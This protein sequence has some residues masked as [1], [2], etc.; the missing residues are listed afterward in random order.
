MAYIVPGMFSAIGV[1]LLILSGWRWIRDPPRR[2]CPGPRLSWRA[3]LTPLWFIYRPRCGYDLRGHRPGAHGLIV[4]PECARRI[5]RPGQMVRTSRAWRPGAA[6]CL[7]IVAA[8]VNYRSPPLAATTVVQYMPTE[9]LLRGESTLGG[10]T[11]L[12]MREEIRRRAEAFELDDDQI[13]RFVRLLVHDLRDDH[14]RGNAGDALGR[15]R[16]FGLICPEPLIEALDSH[17]VQQ[18]S[19]AASVLRAMPFDAALS[20]VLVRASVQDLRSD[21]R[22][23]NELESYGWLAN[24]VEEA[25][26]L[27]I[28][29]MASDDAQQRRDAMELLRRTTTDGA[30]FDSL[31]RMSVQDLRSDDREY[32]AYGGFIFLL[33]HA[34]AAEP[35]LR[36]A[37]AGD[38]AQQRLLSAAVAGCAA[39]RD[40]MS[41][42]VLILVSHLADN[43]IEGDAIVAARALAGFGEEVVPLLQPYRASGD[44]QQRQQVEYIIRR[45]TTHESAAKLQRELPLARLTFAARDALSVDPENLDIPQFA[46][47][48]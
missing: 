33:K 20:A 38:D 48:P 29:A 23:W 40:L 36:Q 9:M 17:D 5:T 16:A 24:H 39:Q 2:L 27:L 42:A 3:R 15:L 22:D 18:R 31:L 6:G 46:Q 28:E 41:Q 11:P 30:V 13:C 35:L 37:M 21:N 4:C 19:M 32:N 44:P 43:H 34:S 25:K 1:L 8:I 47:Q 14:L 10:A 26:P 45:L 12:E 7:C